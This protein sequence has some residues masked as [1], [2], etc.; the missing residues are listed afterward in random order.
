MDILC[1]FFI[2][3]GDLVDKLV[4]SAVRYLN[5]QIPAVIGVHIFWTKT[6]EYE[7]LQTILLQP[8]KGGNQPD[9]QMCHPLP[10]FPPQLFV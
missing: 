1:S 7:S 5:K 9:S 2:T 4:V 3:W 10:P 8:D 6:Q